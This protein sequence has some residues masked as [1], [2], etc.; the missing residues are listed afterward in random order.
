MQLRRSS[1]T[2]KL[3]VVKIICVSFVSMDKNF[4]GEGPASLQAPIKH[5]LA[6]TSVA[7]TKREKD[8]T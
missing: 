3:R 2:F 4:S 5:F 1:Q 6:L 7:T 8:E